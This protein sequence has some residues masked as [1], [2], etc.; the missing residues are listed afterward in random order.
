MNPL[1]ELHHYGQ[2]FWYDNIQRTLLQDGTL[3]RLIAEDGLRGITSNPSIFEKAIGGSEDYDEQMKELIAAGAD[4]TAVYEAL[5]IT[6]IQAA[7]D[8]FS[9]LYVASERKDGYVSL[10]VSPYLARDTAGTVAEARRLNTAVNR[11]NVMIKVP[12]TPQGIPAIRQ[13]IGEG[14]NVNVTLMFSLAHYEAVANAY[15]DGLRDFVARGGDPRKVASVA[16]FFVSRVDTAVDA[17]L[18]QLDDPTAA[19]YLGK[20]AVANSKFVYQHFKKLFRGP[21]FADLTA[22]GARVQRLLWASTSA[23]NPAYSPTLYIDELIGPQTVSTIPPSTVDAFRQSGTVANTL[24]N[25]IPAA[26]NVLACLD[27]FR[28]DLD[29]ITEKL[30]EEGVDAFARSFGQLM[31]T[32]A[33]KRDTL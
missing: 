6:D 27:D 20:T 18:R 32:I 12:A 33:A 13:L 3:Q 11:P 4:D 21:C 28:I 25:D 7:C 26:K 15:M 30:Q 19:D 23:K 2:S 9:E 8:L 16:S 29:Q 10:E 1:V 22:V 24:E 5:V 14:I 17:Q 31:D